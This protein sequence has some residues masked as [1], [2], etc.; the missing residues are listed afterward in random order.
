MKNRVL[1]G[2]NLQIIF[3]V[4]LFA[5][6]GVS[7]ITPA[8]PQIIKHYGLSVKQI[9]YLITVF[10][11]PGI[12]LSPFMGILADRYG[13]KPILLISLFL[14]GTAGF[15][16]AFQKDYNGLLVMRFIQGTG[17]AA[18]GLLNVTLIGDIY[19]GKDRIKAM[20]YNASVLSIGTASFPA[21]GG[22]LSSFEWH[23]AFFLPVL[24]IPYLLL[25]IIR[26]D[27]PAIHNNVS[28]NNYLRNVAKTVNR[29]NV[30]GLF[31]LNILVFIILYGALL[32]FFPILMEERFNADS[33]IIGIS[34]SMMS[35][36]TA[37]SASQLGKIRNKIRSQ[38]LL[39]SSSM[40]YAV[41]LILLS[42]AFNWPVLIGAIVIFG[43]GHG[44]LIPNIQTILVSL[45]PLSERAAFMSINSMV[46]RIGQTLGP[47]TVAFFYID[48]NIQPVF[49]FTA[50]VALIMIVL[51]RTMVG[52]P[53]K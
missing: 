48:K 9:G 5:V 31:I 39:Y 23:Y 44:F 10:T 53:D 40:L 8:F 50:F 11:L 22:F 29:R 33:L 35:V 30:W 7:S 32:S 36:T 6:M 3:G 47:L 52:D 37:V 45:A 17:A 26:L 38:K 2:K 27:T 41:S 43:I 34:M 15:L 25:I 4:T 14:F 49:W 51:I 16:C 20:G 13:R 24:A 18:L 12:V 19:E 1:A 21:V 28:L 46:L 42:V